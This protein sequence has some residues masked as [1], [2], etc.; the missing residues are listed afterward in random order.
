M[1]S[2]SKLLALTLA[3]V[4]LLVAARASYAGSQDFQLFNRTG[5]DIH[6]LYI[7]PSAAEDWSEEMLNGRKIDN[8]A[9]VLVTFSPAEQAELWDIWVEDAEGNALYWREIDLITATQ[10]ILEADG[11]ARIK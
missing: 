7:S 6:A 11:V 3:L 5:A 10:I 4:A 1:K 9:D 2:W 8:G